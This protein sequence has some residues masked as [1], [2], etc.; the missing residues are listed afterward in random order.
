MPGAWLSAQPV[1][2]QLGSTVVPIGQ[3]FSSRKRFQIGPQI[4]Q[5]LAIIAPLFLAVLPGLVPIGHFDADEDAHDDYE[6]V[7]RHREPVLGFRMFA[8][9]LG[10]MGVPSLL[11]EGYEKKP[12]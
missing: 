12:H 10:I 5:Q 4:N 9:R 7:E 2:H 8:T 11:T 3:P 6:E 1:D